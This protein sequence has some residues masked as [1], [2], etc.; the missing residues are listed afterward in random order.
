M[1]LS[2]ADVAEVLLAHAD[3]IDR[4]T[5]LEHLHDELLSGILRQTPHKH[6]LTARGSLPRGRRRQVCET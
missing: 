5:L 6:R 3:G 2:K 1:F 4:A